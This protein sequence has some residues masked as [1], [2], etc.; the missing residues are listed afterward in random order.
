MCCNVKE[1]NLKRLHSESNLVTF[2]KGRT[3]ETLKTQWRPGAGGG[4]V[5]R[6]SA[7][8]FRARR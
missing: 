7:E 5:S 6:R 2:W 1:A 4:R 3:V 8:G